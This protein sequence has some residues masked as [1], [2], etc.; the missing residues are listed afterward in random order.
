MPAPTVLVVDDQPINV[1][2]LKKKLEREGI[3]VTT[4]YSGLEALDK[5][6]KDR[7]DLI[8][9]DVMMP[10]MDGIEVCQRLQGNEETQSIPVI[11]ITARSSKEGKLEGLG[12]GAVDYITKPIDLDET[13]ARVSTQLRVVAINREMLNLQ[14][15]LVEARRAASVGAVTQ[16]I[17][18]NLNN[19]LGV[20]IG[21]LDLIKAYHDKPDLVKQNVQ[22]V[23]EAV[24]RI[25]AIVKQLSSL[26]IKS[27]PPASKCS[28]QQMIDDAIA[29]FRHELRVDAPVTVNN[30]LGAQLIETNCEVFEDAIVKLLTNAW[31]SY[32]APAG[33][34]RPIWLNTEP[35]GRNPEEPAVQINIEDRGRGLDAKI[36][37]HVFEPFIS[38][39]NTVGVGMGLTIARHAL[40]NMGGEVTL[41]DRQGGGVCAVMVHPINKRVL[42]EQDE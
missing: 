20:V 8:L 5:V 16:G 15:R 28:L 11:F 10:D 38:S 40:R 26:V 32:D 25:V 18:H 27:R 29:R 30:P 6:V 2:L 39:K 12:V 21:Y 3:R 37:D 4:A 33:A 9:L 34:P 42:P 13:F 1:Q 31:E 35:T 7:P 19:L 41:K 23:E 24:Q 14:G 17:A 36:R 22:S